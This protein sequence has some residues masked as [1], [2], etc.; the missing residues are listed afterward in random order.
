M[1]DADVVVYGATSAGVTAAIAAAD[2]GARVVLLEPGTHVGGMLSGGLSWTDT[3]ATEVLGGLTRRFY[4]AVGDHYGMPLWATPG[5]EPHLAE[6]LVAHMLEAAGVEVVL[7][8]PLCRV[9]MDGT[10]IGSVVTAAGAAAA[11]TFL[12]ASYEGDLL[13]AAGVRYRVGRESRRLH[14]ETWAGCQPATRPGKH[15]FGVLVSPFRHTGR[16]DDLLPFVRAPQMDCHGWPSDRLGEGDGALQAYAFRLCLTDRP[17]NRLPFPE[18]QAYDPSRFE[19]LARYLE[20]VGERAVA[21]ELMGLVPDLLP[22]GKC[23]VNSIGP[24]SLNLLDGSNRGYPDGD[25]Q[26]RRA[27]HDHHLAF[28]QSLMYFLCHDDRVPASVRSDMRRWGLCADEFTDSDGWPHR[29]YVREARRMVGSYVLTEADLIGRRRHDDG[30]GMGSYNIDVREVQRTW[31]Y[32]PEFD[33][34]AAVFNEGYLSVRV[35][36]YQ[37]PYG[38]L[39]PRADECTNLIVPVCVSASH[40]AFSSLR[41]EPTYMV[42]GEAA[43]RAAVEASRSGAPVQH[44]DVAGLQ[45]DLHDRGQVLSL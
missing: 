27:I 43:G 17:S 42:M 25:P 41:M 1:L 34:V 40:V 28:T 22:G 33:R 35:D 31:R 23:D 11:G 39:V 37:I 19:L 45:A 9:R 30:I 29:L 4:A 12:D 38:C 24:F 10:R 32:L 15:N 2:T 14:G 6:S 13:A 5:P 20:A 44:L 26:T 7:C 16:P 18:P 21:G 8:A 3:G 36:P